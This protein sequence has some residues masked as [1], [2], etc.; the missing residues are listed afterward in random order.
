MSTLATCED[1]C[2][3]LNGTKSWV[4]SAHEGQ[5]A[6]VFA[7]VDKELKHKG[8]SAFIVPTNTPGLTVGRKEDKLGIKAT[9]TANY[10]LDNVRI[11]KENLLRKYINFYF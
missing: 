6:V 4:T 1:N 3:V 11:P 8:I 9:S 2:Y 5:A 7:T 10:F